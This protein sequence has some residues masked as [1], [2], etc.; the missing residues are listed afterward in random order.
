MRA[1]IICIQYTGRAR[2]QLIHH[3]I[4]VYACAYMYICS[5]YIYINEIVGGVKLF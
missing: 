3:L 2:H 5:M 4:H 1:Y